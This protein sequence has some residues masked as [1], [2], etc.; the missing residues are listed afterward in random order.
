M[1]DFA[2]ILTKSLSKNLFFYFLDLFQNIQSN[3][4]YFRL[5]NEFVSGDLLFMKRALFAKNRGVSCSLHV[6][7]VAE[8]FLRSHTT[9]IPLKQLLGIRNIVF[10]V[11]VTENEKIT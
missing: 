1:N 6:I 2:D 11:F 3:E 8:I 9:D 7:F 5:C 4:F 10:V